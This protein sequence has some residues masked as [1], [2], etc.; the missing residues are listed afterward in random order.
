MGKVIKRYLE[1][2]YKCL[3]N[4]KVGDIQ[5]R[6]KI[7]FPT[8]EYVKHSHLGYEMASSVILQ[9]KFWDEVPN[10]PKESFH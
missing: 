10:F 4:S 5:E 9:E 1:N 6:F 7:V 2:F 8:E 3:S